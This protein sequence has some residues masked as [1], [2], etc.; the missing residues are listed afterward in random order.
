VRVPL[1]L[2]LNTTLAVQLVD[3]ARLEPQVVEEM[4]KSLASVPPMERPE[5]V[6]VVVPS[7]S[8]VAVMAALLEPTS[9]ELKVKRVG[10]AV[11]F[12]DVEAV[13]VPASATVCGLLL[14]PSLKLKV[15]VRLPVVTGAKYTFTVQLEEA[16]TLVPQ[17]LDET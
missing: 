1:V 15:A 9:V 6:T 2:G 12:P 10:D 17:V 7:F 14:A 13:A 5:R 11:T 4:V 3:A 8:R 16:A